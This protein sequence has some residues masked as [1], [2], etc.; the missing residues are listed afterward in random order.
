MNREPSMQIKPHV[1]GKTRAPSDS[2][3]PQIQSANE[4]SADQLL[5]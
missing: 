2:F 5:S 3:S 1:N 4:E